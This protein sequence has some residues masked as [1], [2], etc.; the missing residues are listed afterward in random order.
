MEEPHGGFPTT[1]APTSRNDIAPYYG[2]IQYLSSNLKR[3]HHCRIRRPEP[4]GRLPN[5]L[6]PV[7]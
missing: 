4:N 7:G 5:Q 6:G 3:T 1:P 2:D